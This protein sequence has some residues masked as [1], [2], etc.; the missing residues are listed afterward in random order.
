MRYSNS[1]DDI[2]I[3]EPRSLMRQNVQ[4][5]YEDKK[6]RPKRETKRRGVRR[7]R[8]GIRDREMEGDLNQ[9]AGDRRGSNVL[10][11]QWMSIVWGRERRR[12]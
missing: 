8:K 11:M 9:E 2:N 3:F 5:R 6:G 1:D 7:G 4:D 10:E 12:Q